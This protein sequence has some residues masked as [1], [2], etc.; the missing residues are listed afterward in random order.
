M[1]NEEEMQ[2]FSELRKM[3]KEEH[4][5]PREDDFLDDEQWYCENV[6]EWGEKIEVP[7]DVFRD[8]HKLCDFLRNYCEKTQTQKV[9]RIDENPDK[10]NLDK[11]HDQ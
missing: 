10:N 4:P 3:Y 8:P 7:H 1:S 5:E 9:H 11:L 2:M 6:A